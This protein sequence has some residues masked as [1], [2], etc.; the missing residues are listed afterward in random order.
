[1]PSA[2]VVQTP[3]QPA[4][5]I[6]VKEPEFSAPPLIKG[7]GEE[8]FRALL[9]APL[10]SAPPADP[11]LPPIRSRLPLLHPKI[12]P[13]DLAAVL[14]FARNPKAKAAQERPLPPGI[15]RLLQIAAGSTLALQHAVRITGKDPIYLRAAI[16]FYLEQVLWEGTPDPYRVLGAAPDAT[17]EELI[18]NVRCLMSWLHRYIGG[19]EPEAEFAD[20]VL[21]AWNALKNVECGAPNELARRASSAPLNSP[22]SPTW[23]EPMSRHRWPI[24]AAAAVAGVAAIVGIA[25]S[26]GHSADLSESPRVGSAENT[27]M[28]S[29]IT[30][31]ARADVR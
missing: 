10:K 31:G 14:D 15:D 23:A 2:P 27:G 20:R 16:V 7:L 24:A 22:A 19:N 3:E 25:L 29:G 9:T 5:E 6:E 11:S 1:M 13:P 17:R 26:G 28:A 21:A 12:L 18:V 4:S 8:S 30:P